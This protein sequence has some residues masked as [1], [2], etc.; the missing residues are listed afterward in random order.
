M[1]GL[2]VHEGKNLLFVVTR[3][4]DKLLVVNPDTFEIIGRA[5]TGL[6]PWGI[7]VNEQTNRVYVSNFAGGDVWIYD[8][9]TLQVV[10]K[11]AVGTNPAAMA[12]LP[13]LDTV[14]VQVRANSRIVVIQGISLDRG[15]PCRRLRSLW[16][17][18]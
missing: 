3:N 5:E 15:C 7:V 17:C 14:F 9:D 16:H 6:Q 18:R 11:L 12:I 4:P 2:A 10:E 13:G 1:K 8:V